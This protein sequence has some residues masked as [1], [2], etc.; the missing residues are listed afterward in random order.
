MEISEIKKKL[1]PKALVSELF[2]SIDGEGIRTGEIVTFVRL[3][4]CP[5]RCKFCDSMYSVCDPE[6]AKRCKLMTVTELAD[7]TDKTSITPKI[8]L[9]GGEPL[10]N[11]RFSLELVKEYEKRG[12]ETNIETSGAIPIDDYL[13]PHVIITM[14]WKCNC[15]GETSKMVKSNLKLLREGDVLKF[16]VSNE[17]DMD[18]MR[19]IIVNEKPKCWLYASPCFGKI[20]PSRIV[21]YVKNHASEIGRVRLQLQIHKYVWDPNMRGV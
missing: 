9:T 12:Y 1:E 4:G 17:E 11:K 20:Q 14:D 3:Y 2:N 13:L 16:V 8:T 10:M 18:Q 21:D 5:L 19:E 7:L 15:S 6:F